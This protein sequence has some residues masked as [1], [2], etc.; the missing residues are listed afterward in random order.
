MPIKASANPARRWEI[1][2]EGPSRRI[3]LVGLIVVLLLAVAIGVT[4]WRYG[5]ASSKYDDAQHK[6][7][8]VGLI[9]TA[10]DNLL[11]ASA[12]VNSMAVGRTTGQLPLLQ[13]L[14]QSFAENIGQAAQIAPTAAKLALITRTLSH[15]RA[16]FSQAERGVLPA[17][18]TPRIGAAV[19]TFDTLL[20]QTGSSLDPLNSTGRAQALQARTDA[21]S[22]A[23]AARTIA[24]ITAGITALVTILLLA[25]VV[26]LIGRLFDR[27]RSTAERLSG[28]ATE[29]R[30]SA[31][32]SASATSEQSA[33]IAQVAST[34]EELD[35]TAGVIADNARA[36]TAASG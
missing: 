36:G 10:S 8:T 12:S 4:L 2:L 29:M 7:A 23:G 27:I 3:A 33:A 28:A 20:N 24:L 30:A 31:A 35:A 34:I 21:R 5:V 16:L 1:K 19:R 13:R 15:S 17:S 11:D 14:Q 25:Y 22:T 9:E 26:R 32:E 6:G 18:G